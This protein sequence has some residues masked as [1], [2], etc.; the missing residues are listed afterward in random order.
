[1]FF[2]KTKINDEIEI[3]VPI[4]DDEIF[5]ICPSCGKEMEVDINL[6]ADIIKD[7]GD[8]GGTSIYCKECSVKKNPNNL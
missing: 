5:T 8:F 3:R 4:Y 1:V 2:H 6:L 7:G